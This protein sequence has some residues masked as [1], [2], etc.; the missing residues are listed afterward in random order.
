MGETAVSAAS[1]GSMPPQPWIETYTGRRLS[2]AMDPRYHEFV[3]GDI[4]HGLANI[5]RFGGQCRQFYS[6]AEHCC[7]AADWLWEQEQSAECSLCGLLHDA[8]EAYL[9]DMTRPIKMLPDCM[10]A[11]TREH[12]W[13][14]AIYATF[15]LSTAWPTWAESVKSIDNQLCALEALELMRFGGEGWG[16]PSIKGPAPVLKLW[17]PGQAEGEFL[18][19]VAQYARQRGG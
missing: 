15:R 3:L 14:R 2:L 17:T 12:H 8:A 6:V 10:P 19:R 11:T 4:A 16:L 9:G 18:A 1:R 5:C 7:H 13:Q